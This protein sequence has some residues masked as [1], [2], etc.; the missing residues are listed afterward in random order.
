LLSTSYSS[1]LKRQEE[2]TLVRP[3]QITLA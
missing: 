1:D 3:G 2:I